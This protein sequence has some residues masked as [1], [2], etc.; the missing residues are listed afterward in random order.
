MEENNKINFENNESKNVFTADPHTMSSFEYIMRNIGN[1][2][3]KIFLWIVDFLISIVQSVWHFI[4]IVGIGIKNCVIGIGK[5]FKR[6]VK[7]FTNNDLFGRLSFV[8]FGAS[9]F[10]HKQYTNGVLFTLFQV[11]YIV[12]F[13]LFGAHSLY[14]LGTLGIVPSGEPE[15]CLD[16]FCDWIEGDNSIMIL[17]Y[18]LLWALSILVFLYIWNR[19]INSG[20]TNHRIDEFVRFNDLTKENS[21]F[22]HKLDDLANVS[23]KNGVS[24]KEFKKAS[25]PEIA[26]KCALYENAADRDYVKYLLVG[27][28]SHSYAYLKKVEKADKEIDKY[29]KRCEKRIKG[30]DAYIAKHEEL[31]HAKYNELAGASPEVLEKLEIK[32]ERRKNNI[33]SI[34]SKMA[35]KL[36]NLNRK[37]DEVTKAYSTFVDYQNTIN[38]D[39]YGKFNFYYRYVGRIN[40]DLVFYKNYDKFL[41]IFNENL[42]QYDIKNKENAELAIKLKED[43][44]RKIAATQEKFR[45]IREDHA[46]YS[47][48]LSKIKENYK[49]TVKEL[50]AQNSENLETLLLEEKAKLVD[51]TTRLMRKI[52]D[53]PSKK[54]VNA[55]EKEEIKEAKHAYTRDKKYLKTNY[56]SISYAEDVVINSMLVDY[57]IEYDDAKQYVKKLFKGKERQ[58]YSE[59]EIQGIINGLETTKAQ[60]EESHPR[61]YEGRAKTFKESVDGLMNEKFHITILTLPLIGIILFSIV[62]LFFSILVAFTNYSQGHIPPT[63]LFTWIGLENFMT[64]FNPAPDSIYVVLPGALVKTLGWTLIW[65]VVAT[66]SN[67][68]LGII[69]ALLIN[70]DGIKLKKLW[71]TIFILTIAIPQFIS[72]LSIS[73][74]LKDT[75]ALGQLYNQI[76]GS[77]LGFGTLADPTSVNLTKMII[78]LVNIWVGIPYTI[79]S[80]TGILLNIPKDLYE[81]A[82]VDGAGTVT[83]F[84]KI[85]MPYILFVTGPYLITQFVGNINNFNVIFFLTGGG[86]SITGSALLGLGQTDLLI[87]FLYKIITSTNNPQYG[88]ASTVGIVI[89]VI[90]AFF[91]IIMYNKSGAIKE[92]DQFQ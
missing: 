66:F 73:T 56:T 76:T 35:L 64:L 78:I 48:K 88:I 57:K 41:Q 9:S 82:K 65:A 7:Q 26:E 5:F 54:N 79:L 30:I 4:K 22:S 86:P 80:T 21:E 17:I 16:E 24:F 20:Y 38:N 72:L 62:P 31:T 45:K 13:S 27:N 83:Q 77:K 29:E 47:E 15:D 91:S 51:E 34:K 84:V 11:G 39:K 70:K 60:Y 92:E 59:E 42:D 69:V 25:L 28:L 53:L 23:F 43:C 90:C 36:R 67:Y 55:M 50:K 12:L 8:W 58:P 44:D 85:T 52:N 87:T 46:A 6:K 40:K 71:R 74:L 61:K 19:S 89:F 75:G 10:K 37:K 68:I 14:M 18:G 2:F 49:I 1:F 63:Q 32:L 33:L 81:S 3:L